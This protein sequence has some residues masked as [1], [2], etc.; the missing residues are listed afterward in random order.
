LDVI[1][2]T[3]NSIHTA[4]SNS[5]AAVTVTLSPEEDGSKKPRHFCIFDELFSGTNPEEATKSAHAFL[6]YLSSFKNVDFML[7]TH[8]KSVCK[9][10][11]GS[12]V[13][14]N[15]KMDVK[16]LDNGSFDYTYK[17]KKGISS[18]KGAVRVLKDMNYPKEILDIIAEN[19][20]TAS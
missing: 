9:K 4:D 6:Q 18:I 20:N 7:T 17:M 3:E 10:F 14:E 5:S 19:P 16:V 13:I 12:K 2:P 11:R 15:Y 1:K 8:Y